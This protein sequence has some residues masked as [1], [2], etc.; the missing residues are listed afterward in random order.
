MYVNMY[1]NVCQNYSQKSPKASIDIKLTHIHV[2]IQNL[3]NINED[4]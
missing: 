2:N 4:Y 1:I 3:T